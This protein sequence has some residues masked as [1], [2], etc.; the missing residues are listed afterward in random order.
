MSDLKSRLAD[1][2]KQALRAGDK[3]RLVTL[4]MTMAA[5]KQRE[6]DERIELD[7][8]A[9]MAVIE[10]M[11]KQ[12]R[13][14]IAQYRK[15]DR[16][17]LADKEQFEIDVL[18]AYLPEPLSDTE[19]EALVDEIVSNTGATGMQDMGR[20]MGEV[21]KRAAGRAD[22]SRVSGLVKSRLSG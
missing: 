20:V 6:V 11:V 15:G 22:M 5:I 9:V 17:D 18:T 16:D 21:K 10:K 13:E 4:R 1:D 12:R 14:S 8:A 7:D 19:L 3:Q 2:V